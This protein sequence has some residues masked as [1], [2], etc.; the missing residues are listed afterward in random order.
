MDNVRG[1]ITLILIGFF[2]SFITYKKYSFFWDFF[3]TKLLRKYLGNE[4][5]SVA[6]YLVSI[7]LIIA[8][9]LVYKGIVQ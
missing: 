2:L 9:F 1:G 3:N 7:V 6:L 8:G 4:V 5:T